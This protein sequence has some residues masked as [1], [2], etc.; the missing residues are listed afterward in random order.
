MITIVDILAM[1]LGLVALIYI[2]SV[3]KPFINL[4]VGTASEKKLK[5]RAIIRLFGIVG[6]ILVVYFAYPQPEMAA[7]I[8]LGIVFAA[9]ADGSYAAILSRL[10]LQADKVQNPRP[11]VALPRQRKVVTPPTTTTVQ[12]E[13][14]LV[15]DQPPGETSVVSVQ[16]TNP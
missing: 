2:L 16:P 10:R 5:N 7:S 4:F 14:G 1:S 13:V 12:G 8:L 11:V 6:G 3:V 9:I 15:V